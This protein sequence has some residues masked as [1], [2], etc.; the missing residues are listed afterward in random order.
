MKK[1]SFLTITAFCTLLFGFSTY[2]K[3]SYSVSLSLDS[4][5]TTEKQDKKV[6]IQ[7]NLSSQCASYSYDERNLSTEQKSFLVRKQQIESMYADSSKTSR[8][9]KVSEL[10]RSMLGDK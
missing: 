5:K 6:E 7:N 4:C 8:E 9:E 10:K 1:L 3:D 2:G